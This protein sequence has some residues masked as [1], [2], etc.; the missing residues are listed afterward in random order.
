MEEEASHPQNGL[1]AG[2]FNMNKHRFAIIGSRDYPSLA[3]VDRLVD[4]LPLDVIVVSGGATAVDRRAAERARARGLEVEEIPLEKSASAVSG[5][6]RSLQITLSSEK[7][8]AFW[9]GR[10][11][12]TKHDID[13]ALEHRKEIH[14]KFP[15]RQ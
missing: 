6:M 5:P 10:S 11:R 9:D 8:F 3:D 7:V 2:R 1:R 12:G 4:E 15:D 13:L 14:V